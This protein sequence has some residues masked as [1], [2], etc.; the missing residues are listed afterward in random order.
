ML[1]I[2]QQ[3]DA[4]AAGSYY[5]SRAE[6]YLGD[7]QELPS[8]W[9][10][11][12]AERLGL[13]GHVQKADFDALCENR[14]P[15][16]GERL[17]ARNRAGRTVG[18]DFNFHPPKS[19]SVLY[20]L[21]GRAELLD[22][23]RSA[24]ALTMQEMEQAMQTRVRK[25]G[26]MDDRVTGNMLFSEHI[27]LT[28]RPVNGVPDP[29]MHAHLFCF[30]ATFDHVEAQWKAS[31]IADIYRDA[32]Y[33][34]AVFHAH[35]AKTLAGLG[36][37]IERKGKSWEIAGLDALLPK[38]SHRSAEIEQLAVARGI[39]DPAAKDGLGAETR[40]RK[41]HDAGMSELRR[42]WFARLDEDDRAA[43]AAV[44]AK[45]RPVET[46]FFPDRLAERAI[47]RAVLD[48]FAGKT[49]LVPERRLIASALAASF[50]VLTAAEV[51]RR[52]PLHGVATRS[53]EGQ[54]LCSLAQWWQVD[55]ERQRLQHRQRLANHHAQVAW[56][57]A[58][59]EMTARTHGR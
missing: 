44:A 59:A 37:E 28:A 5:N 21:T 47:T 36:Y 23:F 6:Y 3:T 1:R 12:A 32:P 2:Q 20:A 8:S 55:P 38:F 49:A 7:G 56:R 53:Y 13:F 14:N 43:L 52:L 29:H 46:G 22:A 11:L 42:S 54:A 35:L 10:G 31:K 4:K 34:Q 24:L 15:E 30:N 25:A 48:A 18:Y 27:H 41:R 19:L 51:R 39:T 40:Q 57:V 17:T 58:P 50:G 16:T 33:Y 45:Q 26:A 9:G